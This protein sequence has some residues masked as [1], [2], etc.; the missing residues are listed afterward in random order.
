MLQQYNK[1]QQLRSNDVTPE[2]VAEQL[3]LKVVL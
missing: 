3:M 2:K 1:Q